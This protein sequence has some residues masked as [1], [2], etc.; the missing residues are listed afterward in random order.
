MIFNGCELLESVTINCEIIANQMFDGCS[1]L[2]ELNLSQNV[3]RIGD[4]AFRDCSSLTE[5]NLPEDITYIGNNA[6][7]NCSSLKEI[8]L[9]QTIT[10]VGGSA[11]S[12]CDKITIYVDKTQEETSS[13]DTY[14]YGSQNVVYKKDEE[15]NNS[16]S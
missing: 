16:A 12:R 6:F 2:T 1:N 14:W 10:Y 15:I 9:P 5:I 7:D 3:T 11:F 8:R 13:W 4:S